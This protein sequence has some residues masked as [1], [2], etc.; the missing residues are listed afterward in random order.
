MD[1]GLAIVIAVV[2][3][4]VLAAALVIGLVVVPRWRGRR[5]RERFGPEYDRLAKERGSRREAERELAE[6]E[7]RHSKLNLRELSE[8]TR[9]EY[10]DGWYRIQERFVDEPGEAVREADELLT[11]LMIERGYPSEGQDQR[12]ADLSVEHPETVEHYRRARDISR[13]SAAGEAST[14]DLRESV[15]SYRAL[16]AELLDG[17]DTNRRETVSHGSPHRSSASGRPGPEAR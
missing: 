3:A 6:R 7:K 2:A 8:R 14:E 12:V 17:E 10:A 11:R 9:A 4:L 5:L 16:F 15:V 13:R 1:T